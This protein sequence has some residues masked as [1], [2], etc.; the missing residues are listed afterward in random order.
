VSTK[1]LCVDDEPAIL[2]A[3]RRQFHGKLQL[4]T[5]LGPQEGLAALM[6]RGPY[7]VVVADMRMPVMDGA[8]FLS[9]V[10]QRAPDTVRIMLTGNAEQE[11]AVAA[12]N[13]ASVFRFLNKPCP[14]E[15]LLQAVRDGIAAHHTACT[16]RHLLET[17]LKGCIKILTE[18]LALVNPSAAG[19]AGLMREMAVSLASELGVALVWQLEVASMLCRLG[20]VT[21]PPELASKTPDDDTLGRDGRELVARV[22]E[23][24]HRLLSQIPRLEEVAEIVRY[25]EK[26]FDGAGPPVDGEKGKAI[27][28]G[29]RILK[30]ANEYARLVSRGLT[31]ARALEE[32]RVRSGQFDPDVLA[33]LSLLLARQEAERKHQSVRKI[34][35]A[36]L[37]PGHVIAAPILSLDGRLLLREGYP[38]SAVMLERLRN[39]A[40]LHGVRQPILIQDPASPS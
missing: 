7:A 28:E 29:A 23:I 1:V 34:D 36:E 16:E 9:E 17:T 18:I 39:L 4:D 19:E 3:I 37:L 6:S 26:A 38:I 11:T 40:R 21:L 8:T 35:L 10:K 31:G 13:K 27:P 22:P 20:A 30:C 5:A 12:V 2:Q 24:G 15:Q 33:A 25:H 32:L 14:P